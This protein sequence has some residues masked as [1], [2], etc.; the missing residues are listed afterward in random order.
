M[1]K[2]TICGADISEF[3]F[4]S[5]PGNK[6]IKAKSNKF[7]RIIPKFNEE[8][9]PALGL[10]LP[11]A[12][13]MKEGGHYVV[14][15]LHS[16]DANPYS[17]KFENG[18]VYL[19][20][21]YLSIDPALAYFKEKLLNGESLCE[22]DDTE[23]SLGFTVPYTKQD[24]LDLFR[25][26]YERD[27]MLIPGTHTWGGAYGDTNGTD[28]GD[29]VQRFI[30]KGSKVV[31]IMEL[32]VGCKFTPFS[33]T[34]E[35]R[36]DLLTDYDISWLVSDALKHVSNGGIV[37]V[38]THMG[39]PLMN[40][41]ENIVYS[42]ILNGNRGVDAL[43]TEGTELN[44]GFRKTAQG[45]FRLIKALHDNGIPI[46][47]RP[48]HEM[49][50]DWFWW[51]ICQ[52]GV[53]LSKEHFSKLWRYMYKLVTEELGIDDAIWVFAPSAG[54]EEGS[55][56][57]VETT[58]PY[59]GDDVVD[60]V[61]VDWYSGGFDENYD[62]LKSKGNYDRLMATGKPV[63]FCEFGPSG[64]LFG[65]TKPYCYDF[66]CLD[67]I[68]DIKRMYARGLKVSYLLTWSWSAS[69]TWLGEVAEFMDD[70]MVVSREELA[71]RWKKIH[72]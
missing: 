61:G 50:A 10:T 37:S 53:N 22:K 60:L 58:Y 3:F 71:E 46:M 55:K 52:W 62:S 19:T 30:D 56:V 24:L 35:A 57:C 47:F 6:S 69:P 65:K 27:D 23:G 17:V 13:E 2:I 63:S 20:G 41:R 14:V 45:T 66:T 59:P 49:N 31:P 5:V 16:L 11:V 48:F 8:I 51:C 38:C 40:F 21:S 54:G 39:C 12:E 67:I 32:D 64:K 72:G 18:N 70:P 15:S 43:V 7:D 26:A 29:T 9:E 33:R 4:Y 25:E 36:E 68:K 42:G 28:L 1:S 34:N 44:E